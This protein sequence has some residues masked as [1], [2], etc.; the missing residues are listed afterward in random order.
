MKYTFL[1]FTLLFLSA[2]V[3]TQ[4]AVKTNVNAQPNQIAVE[5]NESTSVNVKTPTCKDQ[6]TTDGCV[7][8]DFYI[9]KKQENGCNYVAKVG[10]ILGKCNIQ[11]FKNT[12]CNWNQDCSE[13]TNKFLRFTCVNVS[14]SET[15]IRA[16]YIKANISFR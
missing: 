8:T 13:T 11:C 14:D 15:S 6:C 7:D 4:T 16:N 3:E 9:C 12:D 2:C 10:P 1:I 5:A